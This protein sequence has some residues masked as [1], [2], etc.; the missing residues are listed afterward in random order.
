MKIT[1]FHFMWLQMKQPSPMLWYWTD[2]WSSMLTEFSFNYY[3]SLKRKKTLMIITDNQVELSSNIVR[4]RP[5]FISLHSSHKNSHLIAT[6][7]SKD[8]QI[9]INSN[10]NLFEKFEKF[11][12]NSQMVNFIV[13]NVISRLKLIWNELKILS[14]YKKCI[15]S[16]TKG[17]WWQMSD[18]LMNQMKTNQTMHVIW[19]G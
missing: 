4:R 7:K 17:F 12:Q 10:W 8:L 1:K 9:T 14:L 5:P 11:S 18:F 13:I 6:I 16:I 19:T 15:K 2:H 3:Y